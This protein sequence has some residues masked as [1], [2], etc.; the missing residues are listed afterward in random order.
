MYFRE[1]PDQLHSLAL[2]VSDQRHNTHCVKP[3]PQLH[4]S[5]NIHLVIALQDNV[6]IIVFVVWVGY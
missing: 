3:N 5:I 1:P 2:L 4:S 6:N